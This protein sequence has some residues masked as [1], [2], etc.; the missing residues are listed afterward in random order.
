MLTKDQILC[1]LSQYEWWLQQTCAGAVACRDSAKSPF[2]A[3]VE[4]LLWMIEHIR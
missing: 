3:R 2:L 4:H 1:L